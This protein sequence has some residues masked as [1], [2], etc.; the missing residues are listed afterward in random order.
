VN[1]GDYRVI[2]GHRNWQ[3]ETTDWIL[4]GSSVYFRNTLAG[5]A[6]TCG[7]GI[8]HRNYRPLLQETGWLGADFISVCLETRW[9]GQK[10][11]NSRAVKT[12]VHRFSMTPLFTREIAMFEDSS[13]TRVTI[14]EQVDENEIPREDPSHTQISMSK[15]EFAAFCRAFA[16]AIGFYLP[17]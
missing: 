15:L 13:A 12:P 16:D 2:A 11:S 6:E 10:P 5:C 3:I 4:P 1:T 14:Y 9:L 7:T 17:R 8:S